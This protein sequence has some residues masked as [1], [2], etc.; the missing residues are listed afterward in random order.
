MLNLPGATV[1]NLSLDQ[2]RAW[3]EFARG[4]VADSGGRVAASVGINPFGGPAMLEEMR[5]AVQNGD[6]R[7]VTVNATVN[8]QHLGDPG[9]EEFWALA[10]ELA[11]PILVHPSSN[12]PASTTFAHPALLEYGLRPTEVSLSSAAAIL[13]GVLERHPA[14]ELVAGAGGGGLPLLLLRLDIPHR[15][16]GVGPAAAKGPEIP[17]PPSSYLS[18]LYVD[19]CSLNEPTLRLNADMFGADHLLFGTDS[20]PLSIPASFSFDL[21][22]QLPISEEARRDVLGGTAARLLSLEE[23]AGT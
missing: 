21:V 19:S 4:V 16:G 1:D 23:P 12:P 8:G 15:Y 6:F 22:Q 18:R 10:E 20:P 14:L 9:L 2:I 17:Q 7:G 13:T 5:A 11:T 3:N